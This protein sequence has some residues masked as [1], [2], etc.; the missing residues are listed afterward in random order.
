MVARS[1][2]EAKIVDLNPDGK[3][4]FKEIKAKR[5]ALDNSG[6]GEK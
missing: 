3:E 5:D 6:K 1:K 4:K 2:D